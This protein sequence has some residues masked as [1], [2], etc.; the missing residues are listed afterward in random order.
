MLKKGMLNRFWGFILVV[1]LI[2]G[3]MPPIKINAAF[4]NEEGCEGNLYISNPL[5][6]DEING[7]EDVKIKWN[8]VSGAHHYWLTIVDITANNTKKINKNVGKITSYTISYDDKIFVTD[9]GIYKIYVAAMDSSGNVLN[10]KADWN[11]IYVTNYLE[12]EYNIE[13]DTIDTDGEQTLNTIEM[14][15][16][17]YIDSNV[18]SFGVR[19]GFE[20]GA[21]GGTQRTVSKSGTFYDG[22][23]FKMTMSGLEAGTTY[24]YRGFAIDPNTQK[25]IYG[26]RVTITTLDESDFVPEVSTYS[27]TDITLMSAI[28]S[29]SLDYTASVSTEY[30]FVLQNSEIIKIGSTTKTKNFEYEWEG[31]QPNTQYTYRTYAKNKYGTIEGPV[32]SFYTKSD[33]EKPI[34]ESLKSSLGSEFEYGSTVTFSSEASDNVAL[35]EFILYVDNV[36]V[37]Y[38]GDWVDYE[39]LEHSMDTLSVGSHTIMVYAVDSVGNSTTKSIVVNVLAP[40]EPC[41]DA[42]SVTPTS[43]TILDTYTFTAQATGTDK[44]AFYV[45]TYHLG[46]V[47]GTNGVFTFSHGA[48]TS[49]GNRTVYAYPCDAAG[50]PIMTEGSYASAVFTIAQAPRL[51]PVTITSSSYRT[52]LINTAVDLSW[53]AP[54]NAPGDTRYNIYVYSDGSQVGTVITT[55]AL[56]CVIPADYFT[57][58]GEYMLEVLAA[59]EG[60]ESGSSRAVTVSVRTAQPTLNDFALDRTT[61]SLDGSVRLSGF[62]NGNGGLIAKVTVTVL[63]TDINDGGTIWTNQSLNASYFDLSAVPALAASN[64][65][66]KGAGNYKVRVFVKMQGAEDAD[67][68]GNAS[69][70]VLTDARS[71]LVAPVVT[72]SESVTAGDNY[73]LSWI[74]VAN[75]DYYEL[76][77]DGTSYREI[78]KADA[79]NTVTISGKT[80]KNL[81]GEQTATTLKLRLTAHSNDTDTWLA[82]VAALKTITVLPE[83]ESKAMILDVDM[84]SYTVNAGGMAE[85]IVTTTPDV[86]SIR[87]KDGAGSFIISTWNT[88]Y[89][90]SNGVRTWNVSQQINDA[91][92]NNQRVLTFYSMI[93]DTEYNK[94]DVGFTCVVT[95]AI[96]SFEIVSP[97]HE[98]KQAEKHDLSITWNAP[99]NVAVDYYI[100]R[101]YHGEVCVLQQEVPAQNPAPVVIPGALLVRD[102]E[103]Y[104]VRITARKTGHAESTAVSRFTLICPHDNTYQPVEKTTYTNTGSAS[105]HN[106]VKT[107]SKTCADCGQKNVKIEKITGTG[108]HNWVDLDNGGRVCNFC[109]YMEGVVADTK[110]YKFIGGSQNRTVYMNVDASGEP[111]GVQKNEDG[112]IRQVFETDIITILGYK[113]NCAL[114]RYPVGNTTMRSGGSYHFGFMEQELL[115]QTSIDPE[116]MYKT[117]NQM[118]VEEFI[119]RAYDT[120]LSPYKQPFLDEYPTADRIAEEVLSK[121][122]LEW[123]TLQFFN[124]GFLKSFELYFGPGRDASKLYNDRFYSVL[125]EAM[126]CVPYVSDE[127]INRLLAN[128]EYENIDG[129]YKAI[130][131]I[132][133]IKDVKQLKFFQGNIKDTYSKYAETLGANTL[134]F[135]KEADSMRGKILDSVIKTGIDISAKPAIQCII[136]VFDFI[137][138]R[139]IMTEEYFDILVDICGEDE[140]PAIEKLQEELDDSRSAIKTYA[141]NVAKEI[142]QKGAEFALKT[143]IPPSNSILAIIKG[144]DLIRG[145]LME[146]SGLSGVANGENALMLGYP[147]LDAARKEL[148]W[149]IYNYIQSEYSDVLLADKIVSAYDIV[150]GLQIYI[151]QNAVLCTNFG[152]DVFIL[153]TEIEHIKNMPI[154]SWQ[155]NPNAVDDEI[156]KPDSA[157][158]RA[159]YMGEYY[160]K[161]LEGEAPES[162]G[163]LSAWDMLSTREKGKSWLFYQ[164]LI[165]FAQKPVNKMYFLELGLDIYRD[166]KL[167][168]YEETGEVAVLFVN[169]QGE[170]LLFKYISGYCFG[171]EPGDMVLCASLLSEFGVERFFAQSAELPRS[172]WILP[173]YASMMT[174]N[175]LFIFEFITDECE[176]LKLKDSSVS[177]HSVVNRYFSISLDETTYENMLKSITTNKD[178]SV[179]RTDILASWKQLIKE[180]IDGNFWRMG[181]SF[182]D[183]AQYLNKDSI[184]EVRP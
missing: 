103:A 17:L 67:M 24:T 48:F 79:G 165:S 13:V 133:E 113:G 58:E 162:W 159:Y 32:K 158:I 26:N 41:V 64:P 80:I 127:D 70:S 161:L 53:I 29:G 93:G 119:Q 131:D 167:H 170:G 156:P 40:N 46:T 106:L 42:V 39:K 152:E 128:I 109:W 15:A 184:V 179:P 56:S 1:A 63:N 38:S 154:D 110:E 174:F 19:V 145:V 8:K 86:T 147:V 87:M 89:S 37:D 98:S 4:P 66:F 105:L 117:L 25:Y 142:E 59:A 173:G 164:R 88:G 130:C 144:V 83:V 72:G 55:T 183:F 123:A 69:L 44:V 82:S 49:S 3:I 71:P 18:D 155:S 175:D 157:Q 45:D 95:A 102:N 57:Q 111:Y 163:A 51:G 73:Q 92:T 54:S 27:A 68:L 14:C 166:G 122:G 50:Q 33:T 60:W 169:S 81:T 97:A 168:H 21:K 77:I 121:S 116:P 85:F 160:F 75:A 36:K 84:K 136:D 146:I 96:G 20:F 91:G 10:N 172:Y 114:I 177:K 150:R 181:A 124:D 30:G 115:E 22:D 61:V 148:M 31:L 104:Q 101:V 100:V 141:E 182:D 112:V 11:A 52:S 118:L 108:S 43:G 65:A 94:C 6:D 12:L 153:N 99:A 47:T 143:V 76:T 137:V 90:D 62:I 178:T 7:Y 120:S 23:E 74:P 149:Y 180:C 16:E 35:R 151:N 78:I 134:K 135:I 139:Q 132:S 171:G 9:G 2:I 126:L 5:H 34:I 176:Y 129:V 107:V 125:R 28:I 138:L 140:R